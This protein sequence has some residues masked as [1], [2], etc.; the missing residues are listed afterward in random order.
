[1][2][3]SESGGV[4]LSEEDIAAWIWNVQK[5]GAKARREGTSNPYHAHTLKASLHA[6]GW[7]ME[8]LRLALMKAD[9]VYRKNQEA[10][11]NG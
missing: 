1:M 11:G 10:C 9:P 4:R 3:A 7:L 8:D 2:R 5:E 6:T